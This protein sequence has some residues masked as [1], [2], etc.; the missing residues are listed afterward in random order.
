MNITLSRGIAIGLGFAA[1]ASDTSAAVNLTFTGKGFGF[2]PSSLIYPVDNVGNTATRSSIFVGELLMSPSSGAPL[3]LYC[4]SPAGT[5]GTGL[6]DLIPFEAAKFGN[7]PPTWATAGGIENAAYLFNNFAGAVSDND[8][9]AAM[10]L[11]LMELIYDSTGPAAV[12]AGG[13]TSGRFK[14]TGLTAAILNDADN[15]VNQVISAGPAAVSS[16]Y[17]A[18]PT[19]VYRPQDPH[20][21]D[22]ITF[23]IPVPEASTSWAA[24][25][26]VLV[27]LYYFRSSKERRTS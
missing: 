26:L 23:F 25:I 1:S 18:H 9:G 21:Q 20:G 27:P 24:A 17:S 10:Q 6:Y 7:N 13:L 2:Q 12:T 22:L 11:A 14:A 19:G 8:H 16:F 3:K 15:Y 4:L 5:V